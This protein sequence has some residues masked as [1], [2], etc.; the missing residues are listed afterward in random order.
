VSAM[1]NREADDQAKAKLQAI[2][3]AQRPAPPL[4]PVKIAPPNFDKVEIGEK[5]RDST[6]I[7]LRIERPQ[8]QNELGQIKLFY[9]KYDTTLNRPPRT[10][11]HFIR[12]VQRE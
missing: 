9:G 8:R 3:A 1:N 2:L 12:H 4:P 5:K 11:Q 7:R 10:V 6:N